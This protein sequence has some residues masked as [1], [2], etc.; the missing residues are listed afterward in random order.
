VALLLAFGAALSF[1]VLAHEGEDHGTPGPVGASV[2]G[3]T[4][5]AVSGGGPLFEAILKYRPFAPGD[6]VAV[7]LYLVSMETNRP[8]AE[9]MV[10]ASLSEGDRST[11]VVFAPRPGGPTGA[12]SATLIPTTAAPMSW[13]FDVTAN[14]DA[15]LIGV[16]GFQASSPQSSPAIGET[17]PQGDKT[18]HPRLAALVA[19]GALLLV[20]A[21]AAGRMT[22]RKG[23][24]A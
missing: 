17:P 21:F 5:L 13:L 20:A 18:A 8:V 4:L 12:Y 11:N 16:T 3:E 22:A 9:A 10:S 1:P 2:P 7:T 24:S 19:V 14:G 15:D 6:T 23:V